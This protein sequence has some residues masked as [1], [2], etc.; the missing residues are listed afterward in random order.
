MRKYYLSDLLIRKNIIHD[1]NND[2]ESLT[3]SKEI[4]PFITFY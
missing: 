1:K 4:N 2:C 3:D